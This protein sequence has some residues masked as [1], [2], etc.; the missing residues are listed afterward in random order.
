MT[1]PIPL[2]GVLKPVAV[3]FQSNCMEHPMKR[4]SMALCVLACAAFSAWSGEK[5]D[6]NKD[7]AL[8]VEKAGADFKIQGEYSGEIAAADGKKKFGAHIMAI[9]GGEFRAVYYYGGL[10]GDGWDGDPKLRAIT[11]TE[12]VADGKT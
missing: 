5:V 9:G 10:P 12:W 6:V 11:K 1:P 7:L 3:P 8:D 4:I 2:L